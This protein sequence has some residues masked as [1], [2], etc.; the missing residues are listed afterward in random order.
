MRRCGVGLLL[1]A[2]VSTS[3]ASEANAEASATAGEASQL[4]LAGA[5][6][7]LVHY[8]E[9]VRES[10]S[11]EVGHA[12]ESD[13]SGTPVEQW[14]DRIWRFEIE[15]SRLRWTDYPI[16]IFATTTG[17]F[18]EIAGRTALTQQFWRPNP[19]Q[20]EEIASGLAT[21]GNQAR[22][23]TLRKSRDASYRSGGGMRTQSTS[24][25]GYQEDW[26]IAALDDLPVF[27]QSASMTSGRSDRLEGDTEY[28]VS[29]IRDGGS[30]VIGHFRRDDRR[31][32]TFEMRRTG[33]L[34]LIE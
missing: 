8:R 27:T 22:T 13:A 31:R 10:V 11:N 3:G 32:G 7:I 14:E 17:R 18:Q 5:W 1:V 12:S 4:E 28:R 25:V 33:G 29:E 21:R 20:L 19:Q 16:A 15:G 23:K 9:A 26:T 24:V 34:E 30:L 6:H 2:F